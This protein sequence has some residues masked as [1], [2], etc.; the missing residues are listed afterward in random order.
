MLTLA[1]PSFIPLVMY[2]ATIVTNTVLDSYNTSR[3]PAVLELTFYIEMAKQTYQIILVYDEYY[4]GV[5]ALLLGIQSF[6]WESNPSLKNKER[7]HYIVI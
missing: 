1:I 5:R 7:P 6:Y 4:E 3:F 2:W